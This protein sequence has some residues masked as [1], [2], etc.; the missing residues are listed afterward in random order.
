MLKKVSELKGE[1]TH[2]EVKKGGQH[3][4]I[5]SIDGDITDFVL[6][7][8]PQRPRI[9]ETVVLPPSIMG[10]MAFK[11]HERKDDYFGIIYPN[12]RKFNQKKWDINLIAQELAAISKVSKITHWGDSTYIALIRNYEDKDQEYLDS[13]SYNWEDG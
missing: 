6:F 4:G 1:A 2:L 7:E 12:E 11:I 13:S 3:F 8:T 5:R 9:G 10:Q